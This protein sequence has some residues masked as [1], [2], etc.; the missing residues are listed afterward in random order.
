LASLVI[1]CAAPGQNPSGVRFG[2]YR[3][4]GRGW[5]RT[6]RGRVAGSRPGDGGEDQGV[7]LSSAG[8]HAEPR[9]APARIRARPAVA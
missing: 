6:G 8:S 1:G 9:E 7:T 5:A 2:S 4:R 3:V